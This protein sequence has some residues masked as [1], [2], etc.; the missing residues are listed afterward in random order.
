MSAAGKRISSYPA[1]RMNEFSIRT[2]SQIVNSEKVRFFYRIP[3]QAVAN[4]IRS[5]YEEPLVVHRALALD[6]FGRSIATI[7]KKLPINVRVNKTDRF[8]STE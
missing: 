4:V 3:G 5:S 7:G 2:G 1:N 6:I 8:G